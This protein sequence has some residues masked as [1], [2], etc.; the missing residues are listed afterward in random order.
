MAA[1]PAI[2]LSISMRHRIFMRI[3]HARGPGKYWSVRGNGEPAWVC[4]PY[5]TS[6]IAWLPSNI[7]GHEAA[8]TQ[9]FE[10]DQR[11][12]CRLGST[13]RGKAHL[14]YSIVRLAKSWTPRGIGITWM[15][16]SEP[17]LSWTD[18]AAFERW[19]LLRSE[20]LRVADLFPSF[21]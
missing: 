5:V 4:L 11:R 7:V 6:N 1:L 3:I 18:P 16:L 13:C 20:V 10:F 17:H 9:S 2:T 8:R 21:I 14:P 15:L 12:R 19:R